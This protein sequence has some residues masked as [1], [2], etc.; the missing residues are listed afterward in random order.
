MPNSA[1]VIN[2]H[3]ALRHGIFSGHYPGPTLIRGKEIGERL[4]RRNILDT[5]NDAA[6]S[7]RRGKA[8]RQAV[9]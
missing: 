9:T 6:A 3:I 5:A 8:C 1:G 7:R 4:L 2:R